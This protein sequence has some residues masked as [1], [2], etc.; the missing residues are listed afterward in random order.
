MSY[1]GPISSRAML[2]RPSVID[3]VARLCADYDAVDLALGAPELSTPDV[4]KD[5]AVAALLGRHNQ[6][7]NSWGLSSLR[8]AIA[9]KTRRK[10]CVETNPETE[11][12]VTCGSTEAM[13]NVMMVIC[14]SGSEVI[15]FE[16]FFDNYIPAIEVSQGTVRYVRMRPPEWQFDMREL[17][18]AFNSRTRAI[19]VNTPNNPTGKVFTRNELEFIAELCRRWNVLCVTDEVYEH[20]IFDGLQH[21]SML[22]IDG[23][24]ERTIVISGVSKTYNVTGWRV[25]YVIAPERITAAIRNVHAFTSY[26]APTPF[27]AAATTALG[28]EDDYYKEFSREIQNR[29]DVLMTALEQCGFICH[30]PRGAFYLLADISNFGFHDDVGFIH[31]LIKDI[32][33][34]AVPGGSFY[35][36]KVDGRNLVRFCFG[37]ATATLARAVGRLQKLSPY[38]ASANR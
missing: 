22:Q 9:E 20:M 11:I 36:E 33:V 3:E 18:A 12:T 24:A 38:H 35:N 30:Q 6:Y 37:K 7:T 31:F 17:E 25:G 23:M 32:G 4:V 1:T 34:A 29:R 28:L 2:F 15:V 13:L 19:I 14:D 5:A 16:P 27:Q 8:R 10:L 26:C 21:C